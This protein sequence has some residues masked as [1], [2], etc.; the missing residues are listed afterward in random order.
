MKLE[1]Q[2][3]VLEILKNGR[4]SVCLETGQ[5]LSYRVAKKEWKEIKPNILPSGYKQYIIFLGRFKK[6]KQIVYG[7]QLVWLAANGLYDETKQL[8]HI[9]FNKGNNALSNLELVTPQANVIHSVPNRVYSKQGFRTI[10]SKDIANI[11][12][13]FAS[14]VTGQSEIG[15]RL[16]LHRLS[17]RYILKQ[18]EKGE[19]LKYQ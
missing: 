4:Y 10:R 13:L 14:G 8:N 17:V 12:E 3:K 9:D 19:P 5:I 6:E 16:N 1:K 15:R 11:K 7:H 18:I 2:H